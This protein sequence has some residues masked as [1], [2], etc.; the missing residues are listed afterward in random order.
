MSPIAETFTGR[1][2]RRTGMVPLILIECGV[3]TSTL[4]LAIP[5]STSA[6]HL[7]GIEFGSGPLGQILMVTVR[8][9][10]QGPN[11]CV[12]VLEG[13]LKV[14]TPIPVLRRFPATVP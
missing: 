11:D 4:S 3:T 12:L 6:M 7:G 5:I 2:C 9:N 14:T 1:S 13:M 8:Q 10:G